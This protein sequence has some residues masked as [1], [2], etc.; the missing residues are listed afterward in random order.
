MMAKTLHV[1]SR[2]DAEAGDDV[3]ELKPFQAKLPAQSRKAKKKKKTV[4][5]YLL[6]LLSE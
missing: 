3:T 2:T 6:L 5:L 4:L 1:H